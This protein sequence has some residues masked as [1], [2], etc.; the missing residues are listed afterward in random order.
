MMVFMKLMYNGDLQQWFKMRI[1][2]WCICVSNLLGIQSYLLGDQEQRVYRGRRLRRDR[3]YTRPTYFA[4][5][6][7]T[8]LIL[9]ALSVLVINMLIIIM[10][11]GLGH[12]TML[13]RH[14]NILTYLKPFQS[15]NFNELDIRALGTFF[16]CLTVKTLFFMGIQ[17]PVGHNRIRL[18][19]NCGPKIMAS[20][21]LLFAVI[22]F[23]IGLLHTLVIT[24]LFKEPL[25]QTPVLCILHIWSTGV[26]FYMPT[27]TSITVIYFP[28]ILHQVFRN[29][30]R[31]FNL[32]FLLTN[33][34]IPS[35][36]TLGL[37]LAVPYLIAYSLVPKFINSQFVR[38]LIVRI[39][40]P[41]VVPMMIILF[42]KKLMVRLFFKL[43]EKVK[44]E[45]YLVGRQL[46]NYD[47]E[48]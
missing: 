19:I 44:N 46:V 24:L 21:F 38:L 27:A 37:F 9:A 35:I 22:P 4:V 17:V 8:L 47:H 43:H 20:I 31:G 41:T 23:L 36:E 3:P 13:F 42:N 10:C 16:I 25:H 29:D 32:K 18:L 30:V 7:V 48:N 6:L 34:I 45:K 12:L 15:F 5:R 1:T 11:V 2:Y 39:I 40:Y 33:V 26:I 14:S 28:Q